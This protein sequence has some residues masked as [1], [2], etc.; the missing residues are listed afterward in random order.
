MR[1]SGTCRSEPIPPTLLESA[2]QKEPVRAYSGVQTVP[3]AQPARDGKRP[4]ELRF[5]GVLLALGLEV[6]NHRHRVDVDAMA[7]LVAMMV[8]IGLVPTSISTASPVLISNLSSCQLVVAFDLH[9]LLGGVE[10]FA[11]RH[12]SVWERF[13]LEASSQ[14]HLLSFR[15]ICC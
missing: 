15:Q 12:V 8:E 1:F 2:F 6:G 4:P 14:P 3:A 9:R 13:H 11:G 7:I 5:L 10:V